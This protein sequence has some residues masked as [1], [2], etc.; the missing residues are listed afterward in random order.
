MKWIKFNPKAYK[1]LIGKEVLIWNAKEKIVQAAILEY[2]SVLSAVQWV[3][4]WAEMP[5]SVVTHY[6]KLPKGPKPSAARKDPET[7]SEEL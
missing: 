2:G 1:N 4:I 7:P 6:M 5:E 3:G